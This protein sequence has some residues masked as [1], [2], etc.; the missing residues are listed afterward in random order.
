[1]SCFEVHDNAVYDLLQP[2]RVEALLK[3]EGGGGATEC[4][5]VRLRVK[6]LSH[7]TKLLQR[8]L[9]V[10]NSSASTLIVRMYLT[11]ETARGSAMYVAVIDNGAELQWAA[12]VHGCASE[13]YR[14]MKRERERERE[15]EIKKASERAREGVPNAS[16]PPCELMG[17]ATLCA[18]G[19]E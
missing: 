3:D 9:P 14:E 12:A 16:I 13:R 15:R 7:A 6:R 4:G 11:R 5:L 18:A 1:V 10:T 8:R 19:L 2:T 17:C